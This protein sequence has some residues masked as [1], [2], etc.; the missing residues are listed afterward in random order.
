M[1]RKPSSFVLVIRLSLRIGAGPAPLA[2]GPSSSSPLTGPQGDF[3]ATLTVLRARPG[4]EGARGQAPA[5]GGA[6]A[7]G[8]GR[9]HLGRRQVDALRPRGAA[10]ARVPGAGG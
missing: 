5:G 3:Q 9:G 6:A 7:A 8:D 2:S 1:R 10:P 4:G